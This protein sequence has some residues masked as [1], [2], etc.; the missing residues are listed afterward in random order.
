MEFHLRVPARSHSLQ[1]VGLFLQF[2]VAF[3]DAYPRT[4]ANLQSAI[5]ELPHVWIFDND[6]LREPFRKVAAYEQSR[7][8][9][10]GKPT[11]EW[12]RPI[13]QDSPAAG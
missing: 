13:L 10:E 9:F 7:R 11:P 4:L 12:L 5:R 2:P 1:F 3:H 6:D 8:V